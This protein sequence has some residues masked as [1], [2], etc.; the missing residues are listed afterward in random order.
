MTLVLGVL[1]ACLLALGRWG[2]RQPGPLL[3][4]DRTDVDQR[5]RASLRRG[6][7]AALAFGVLLLVGAVATAVTT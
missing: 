2:W 5:R 1:G 7:A 4:Q 6:G 3:A